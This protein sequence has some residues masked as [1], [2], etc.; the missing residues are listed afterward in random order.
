MS[1][2]VALAA[3]GDDGGD[4]ALNL[5]TITVVATGVSNMSAASVGEISRAQIQS[6]PIC[7]PR[8]FSRIYLGSSPHSTPAAVNIFNIADVKWNDIEYYYVSRLQN[9]SAPVADY[10]VHS[11]VP[12]TFRARFEYHF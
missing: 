7:T 6:Q 9:E 3:H 5:D 2:G 8:R 10:V 1:L 12:R 11:G 4:R